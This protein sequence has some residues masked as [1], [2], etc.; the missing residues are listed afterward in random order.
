MREKEWGKREGEKGKDTQEEKRDK[1][2]R[3]LLLAKGQL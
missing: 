2:R 1:T 3:T